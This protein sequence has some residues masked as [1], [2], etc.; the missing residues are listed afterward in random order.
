MEPELWRQIEDLYHRALELDASERADFIMSAAGDNERL[1][2]EV[3]SLLARE[4]EAERFI[5]APAMAVA[6]RLVGDESEVSVRSGASAATSLTTGT[7]GAG[8]IIG[9]YHLLQLIG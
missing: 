3:E 8:S 4:R 1:R 5:E 9:S 7:Q 6:A 2:Q